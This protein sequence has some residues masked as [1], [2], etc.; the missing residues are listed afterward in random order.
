MKALN[1]FAWIVGGLATVL[2]LL[3]MVG[4]FFKIPLLGIN[5]AINYFHVANS[6]LLIAICCVLLQ[7]TRKQA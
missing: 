1:L 2:V 3:G 6:L 7:K 4:F 5:H